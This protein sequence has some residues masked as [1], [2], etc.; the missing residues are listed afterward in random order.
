MRKR[1]TPAAPNFRSARIR[2]TRKSG[3]LRALMQDA[4]RMPRWV[5]R[6]V[7]ASAAL[8]GQLGLLAVLALSVCAVHVTTFHGV[9]ADDA[10]I[11]YRYGQNLA[12]GRGLVFNPGQRV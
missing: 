2:S 7:T 3:M 4:R 12:S 10:Y 5:A 9:R 8:G 6:C 1:A 11:T